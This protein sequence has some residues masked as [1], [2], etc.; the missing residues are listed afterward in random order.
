[1]VSASKSSPEV[2][3]ALTDL[4]SEAARVK[5]WLN[6]VGTLQGTPLA[7][8]VMGDGPLSRYRPYVDDPGMHSMVTKLRRKA[9]KDFR[10]LDELLILNYIGIP[11]TSTISNEVRDSYMVLRPYGPND[12]LNMLADLIAPQSVTLADF[13]RDHYLVD[14]TLRQRTIA[15]INTVVEWLESCNARPGRHWTVL[16]A[17]TD[18]SLAF[19]EP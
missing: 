19:R 12:G 16:S 8:E 7:D 5:A 15:L 13:G 4:G 6:I 14:D 9:Y 18:C 3:L 17:A 2:A 10:F 11:V 1:M